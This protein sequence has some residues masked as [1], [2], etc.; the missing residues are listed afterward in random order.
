[1]SVSPEEA[2]DIEALL[3]GTAASVRRYVERYVEESGANY[4][5]G[6]FQWGDLTHEEASKS[7]RL[8]SEEVMPAF[9]DA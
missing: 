8:F 6:S 7:L 4:F 9:A 5:V 2:I 1:M 3:V